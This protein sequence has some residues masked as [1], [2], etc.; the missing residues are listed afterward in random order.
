MSKTKQKSKGGYLPSVN[1]FARNLNVIFTAGKL[2]ICVIT[3]QNGQAGI[4]S[5]QF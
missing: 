5:I 2:R 4:K 3:K 1:A